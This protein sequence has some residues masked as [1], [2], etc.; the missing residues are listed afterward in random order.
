MWKPSS[1]VLV[2]ATASFMTSAYHGAGIAETLI[3]G[4]AASN[5]ALVVWAAGAYI[6]DR[7]YRRFSDANTMHRG[8]CPACHTF[9]SLEEVTSADPNTR[10]VHCHACDQRFAISFN[11]QR[12]AAE[13]LGK[14]ED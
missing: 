13:R 6:A 8:I 4:I 2:G 5:A 1:L 12:L 3:V 14:F 9:N 10:C 11:G 7:T